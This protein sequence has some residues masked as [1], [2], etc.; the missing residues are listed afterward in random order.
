MF[1]VKLDCPTCDHMNG[2]VGPFSTYEQA[3]DWAIHRTRLIRDEGATFDIL[4][5]SSPHI[6]DL[7]K[8]HP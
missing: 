3:E 2:F 8:T 7:L 4:G 6:I 1:I 5:L